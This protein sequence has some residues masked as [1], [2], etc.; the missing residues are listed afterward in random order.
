MAALDDALFTLILA[1]ITVHGNAARAYRKHKVNPEGF[2]RYLANDES[3]AE[4]YRVAKSAGCHRVAEQILELQD[5]KPKTMET[6]WGEKIDPGW[7][8]HQKNRVDARKWVLCHLMPKVYGE[9]TV[10]AGDA[11]N[12][13]AVEISDAKAALLRGLTP[14]VEPP[15]TPETDS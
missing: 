15:G 11:D 13:L 1:E 12:P 7:V 3:A 5:A 10:I 6:Q 2:Y 4:R 14:K 9:R 8:Q